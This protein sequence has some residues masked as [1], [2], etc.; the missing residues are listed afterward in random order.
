MRDVRHMLM[1]T[2]DPLVPHP[3]PFEVEIAIAN[4]ERYKTPGS[5][6]SLAELIR[7][8]DETLRLRSINS[9]IIF[10]IRTNCLISEKSLLL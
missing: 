5:D 9:L 10:G 4:L 7:A 3:S 2:P 8:G 6:R 1:Y